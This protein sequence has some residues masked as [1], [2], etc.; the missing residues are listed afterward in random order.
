MRSLSVEHIIGKT[1]EGY[2]HQI[3]KA[4]T[5]AFP[6][7]TKDQV[8]KLSEKLDTINTVSAHTFCNSI[9]SRNHADRDMDEMIMKFAPDEETLISEVKKECKKTLDFKAIS[10]KE[11]IQ[12]INEELVKESILNLI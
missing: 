11:K 4:V 2:I 5:K 3:K 9:T 6:D 12:V 7:Y 10:V 1:Q 8:I